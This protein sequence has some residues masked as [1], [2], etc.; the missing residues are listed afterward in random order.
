MVAGGISGGEEGHLGG[1]RIA[2]AQRDGPPHGVSHDVVRI[3]IDRLDRRERRLGQPS[4]RFEGGGPARMRL[5][6]SG[7]ASPPARMLRSPRRSARAR[8]TTGH[9]HAR[10]PWL[11]RG[12]A[13]SSSPFSASAYRPAAYNTVAASARNAA[14][15]GSSDAACSY[16][17][18]ALSTRPA[19]YSNVPVRH[20]GEMNPVRAGSSAR[21]CS[22]PRRS[23]PGRRGSR[24]ACR[25]RPPRGGSARRPFR[26]RPGLRSCASA[27]TA[28][29]RRQ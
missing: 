7:R 1:R 8:T 28:R 15:S 24:S 26:P 25:G 3:E 4:G 21:S 18:T 17:A 16:A 22:T 10:A 14:S 23:G 29:T 19:P 11:R 20:R 9:G 27:R 13:A 6:R 2:E 12:R 5:P